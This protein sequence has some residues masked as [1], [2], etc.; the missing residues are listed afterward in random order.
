MAE[1]NN[2]Q[3]FTQEEENEEFISWQIPEHNV[4]ERGRTWYIVFSLVV[5]ALLLYGFLTAN[6]LLAVIAIIAALVI[7]LHDSQ[8]PPQITFSITDEGVYLGKKFHDF[9]EFE[10]FAIVYKPNQDIKNLY[11][12]FKNK[13]KPMLSIPL[14][15]RN[16]VYIRNILS[17]YLEEDT[18][19]TDPPFSEE[20]SRLFKI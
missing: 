14:K 18:E 7:L 6:F 9:D 1:N 11:L 8:E 19:R 5:G 17:E 13:L 3:N 15:D 16:P 10:Q 4:Y 20:F 12:D 2:D